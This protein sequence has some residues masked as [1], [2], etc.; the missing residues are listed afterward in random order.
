MP[1]TLLFPF[2]SLPYTHLP[3]PFPSLPYAMLPPVLSPPPHNLHLPND[4]LPY[5]LLPSFPPHTSSLSLPLSTLI[6]PIPSPLYP[7]ISTASLLVT[8]TPLSPP[9]FSHPFPPTAR[10]TPSH[11][12]P[13]PRIP[14]LLLYTP[15]LPLSVTLILPAILFPLSPLGLTPD[16]PPFLPLALH[17][18][19]PFS[20]LSTPFFPLSRYLPS[21]LL[22]PFPLF[23]TPIF[24][25]NFTPCILPAFP[26]PSLS[27]PFFPL[28]PTQL[29]SPW[30]SVGTPLPVLIPSP[31]QRPTRRPLC[32]SRSHL[33]LS[34]ATVRA[35]CKFRTDKGRVV[36]QLSASELAGLLGHAVEL[37]CV[38]SRKG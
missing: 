21:T 30:I 29:L 35:G 25:R 11:S 24:P 2:P 3:P 4:T 20:S 37:S 28:S 34:P 26:L 36:A 5:S 8:R 31:A 1:F 10:Y 33:P 12:F 19:P 32:T 6:P 27:T 38:A 14:P 7:S 23:L 18:S 22:P 16:L 13:S 17:P 15:S 9:F